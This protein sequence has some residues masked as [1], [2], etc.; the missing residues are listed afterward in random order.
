VAKGKL[1]TTDSQREILGT[2]LETEYSGFM[3]KALKI[4]NGAIRETRRYLD[5]LIR[6]VH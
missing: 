2:K 5:D 4:W 6:F 3:L 1:V